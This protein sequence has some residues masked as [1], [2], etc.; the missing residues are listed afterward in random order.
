MSRQKYLY[1]YGGAIGDALFGVHIGRTL[2]ANEPGA[3]LTLLS[4]R[5]NNFVRG[6]VD[7]IPFVEYRELHKGSIWSWI[8]ALGLIVQEWKT[9]VHD[10]VTTALP[11]WWRF[12]LW[13]ASRRTGSVEVRQQ[14]H[15]HERA[16][17]PRAR[18]FVYNCATQNLF[19]TPTDILKEWGIPVRQ[20]PLPFLEIPKDI[21]LPGPSHMVFHFFAGNYRRSIPIDHA[22]EL[23]KRAREVFPA[24]KFILT[25]A[26]YEEGRAKHM[27]QGISNV[28]I[29][30]TLSAQELVG[31]LA[32]AQMVVGVA[33]GIVA[34]AAHIDAP[35]IALCNLS[36]PCW[37]P[38]YN[39]KVILLSERAHCGCRGD[40]TGD[41][42]IETPEGVVYRCLYDIPTKDI[43]DAMMCLYEV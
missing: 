8:G 27:S 19:D 42:G 23:L 17:P 26:P 3:T 9:V 2:A 29:K 5:R 13:C 38:S 22:Q 35:T 18:V 12:I 43:I 20:M 37:L 30:S 39:P 15:G 41:C 31:I 34:I 10:P 14:M 1:V 16:V 36:D 28:C 32:S 7:T 24:S 40:K 25:C 11:L 6:L 4:T 21:A 33:S